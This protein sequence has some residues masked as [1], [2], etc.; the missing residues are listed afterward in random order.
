M[1][2]DSER[3]P[4]PVVRASDHDREAAAEQLRAA[5]SD[6]RLELS[7]L[8]DRLT[9]VYQARTRAELTAATG[10][11]QS[12]ELESKPLTLRTK[13]GTLRRTGVWTAPAEIIAECASGSVTLD[14]T[15][16]VA[17]HR[18]TQVHAAAKS[19]RVVMIVPHDWAVVMDDVSSSSGRVVN[20]VGGDPS[21]AR[22]VVRVNGAV[23]AGVIKAR[24]P[25]RRF[26]D[27]LR[28]RPHSA[29]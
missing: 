7:E 14:F 12:P 19:G 23:G 21:S 24:Y 5:V 8:D 13:S 26:V 9:V 28:G 29:R 1:S 2:E 4:A 3:S 22:H 6:G 27:W 16:A 11:L 17:H 25:R 15:R 20:K 18:E 10:D